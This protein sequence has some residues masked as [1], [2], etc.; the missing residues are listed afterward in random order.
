MFGGY[1]RP[2][3]ALVVSSDSWEGSCWGLEPCVMIRLLCCSLLLMTV[4]DGRVYQHE[5]KS[6][7]MAKHICFCLLDV[8][9]YQYIW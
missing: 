9:F 1:D 5:V 6:E 2:A 8:E 4:Q 7:Y 3:M